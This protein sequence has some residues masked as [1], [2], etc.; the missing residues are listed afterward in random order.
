[1]GEITGRIGGMETFTWKPTTRNFDVTLLTYSNLGLGQFCDFL[2]YMG[3][4]A[5]YDFL[6]GT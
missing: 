5:H 1:V 2:K 4:D 6:T 3:L